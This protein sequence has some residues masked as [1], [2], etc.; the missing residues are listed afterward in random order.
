MSVCCVGCTI[1]DRQQITTA[2]F[3]GMHPCTDDR[4]E[5]RQLENPLGQPRH[6][7]K[8]NTKTNLRTIRTISWGS[9]DHGNEP[10]CPTNNRQLLQ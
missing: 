10:S 1:T 8:D 5:E 4:N 2:Q 7:W 6:R 9:C 3:G